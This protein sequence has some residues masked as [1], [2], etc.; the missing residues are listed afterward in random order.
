MSDLLFQYFASISGV[1][2]S[3][4]GKYGGRVALADYCP[5]LQ[6]FVWKQ[7]EHVLRGSRCAL[8]QNT[9]EPSQNHL[10]EKYSPRSK[11]FNHGSS[12]RLQKCRNVL[13]PHSGSGCYE[14]MCSSRTGLTIYVQH[15]AYRCH[16]TGQ[17]LAIYTSDTYWL[18]MGNITCPSCTE[19]CQVM[20]RIVMNFK[21][22][23]HNG[24]KYWWICHP[25]SNPQE[26]LSSKKLF[27]NQC[28]N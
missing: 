13:T 22:I 10:L 11:C 1:R 7:D 27:C 16:Y 4:V 26:Q 24:L 23:E 20:Y 3:D 8:I 2:A 12:W 5:Y 14:Y 15:T 19:V 21:C 18:Y 17:Q 25:G 9:L 28:I 6:E